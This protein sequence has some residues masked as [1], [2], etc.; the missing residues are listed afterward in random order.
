MVLG[1]QKVVIHPPS[2]QD[3]DN[4]VERMKIS[5]FTCIQNII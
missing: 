1:I 5:L 2:K 4:F 3:F